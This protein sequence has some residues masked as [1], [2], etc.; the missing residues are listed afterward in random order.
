MSLLEV[1]H[2]RTGACPTF[3]RPVLQRDGYLLRV[4]LVGGAL[5]S[6][7]AAALAEVAGSQGNGTRVCLP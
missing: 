2:K 1:G 5:T 4:P 7:Q 6:A 3:D